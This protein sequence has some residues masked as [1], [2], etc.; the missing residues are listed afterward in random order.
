MAYE[1]HIVP[2]RVYFVDNRS[3]LELSMLQF[4]SEFNNSWVKEGSRQQVIL[5][6]DYVF[7]YLNI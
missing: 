6:R 1:K 5:G 2:G 3:S 7:S 4:V